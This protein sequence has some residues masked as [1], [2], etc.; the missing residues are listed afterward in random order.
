MQ[1]EA[2]NRAGATRRLGTG[3]VAAALALWLGGTAFAQD[4][5]PDIEPPGGER[6]QEPRTP[7]EEPEPPAGPQDPEEWDGA[8]E[9][10]SDRPS[11]RRR[12]PRLR[13]LP[14]GPD[15]R[16]EFDIAAMASS[17]VGDG[18]DAQALDYDDLFGSGSGI[19][20]RAALPMRFHRTASRVSLLAG[21]LMVIDAAVFD[22]T[23]YSYPNNDELIAD[24]MGVSRIGFG[25]FFRADFGRFFLEPWLSFG[26][27]HVAETDATYD[28]T[29]NGGTITTIRLYERSNVGYI[30]GG[31]RGGV[32]FWPTDAFTIGLFGELGLWASGAPDAGP[33]HPTLGD[34]KPGSMV[35]AR[36]TF[37]VSISFGL[38]DFQGARTARSMR[39][40]ESPPVRRPTRD[41]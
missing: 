20:L 36:A 23:K 39:G 35:G 30:M 27:G 16:L 2:T 10:E 25:G 28:T 7:G 1:T 5:M 3:L 40:G 29:F 15:L 37:G 32:T 31:L 26:V 21:P 24:D 38:G 13:V 9:A 33:A 34:A 6:S 18:H 17:I 14:R 22:G 8:G 41:F 11:L 12:R 4:R 19:S